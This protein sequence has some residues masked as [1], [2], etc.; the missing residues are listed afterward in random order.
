MKQS[1]FCN[2][3]E[4]GAFC[5]LT[6][7]PANPKPKEF[8]ELASNDHEAMQEGTQLNRLRPFEDPD[9]QLWMGL[10]GE[11]EK[12]GGGSDEGQ[13]STNCWRT[14][15]IP[16]TKYNM[17]IFIPN[18]SRKPFSMITALKDSMV[19]EKKTVSS[20][21]QKEMYFVLY[22]NKSSSNGDCTKREREREETVFLR[23][24]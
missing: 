5:R 23:L 11:E 12:G 7:Q 14:E 16:L 17:C 8:W 18:H 3:I 6:S 13:W 10:L 24:T 4:L 2:W 22:S 1:F 19:R 15:K 21:R 20:K 9:C